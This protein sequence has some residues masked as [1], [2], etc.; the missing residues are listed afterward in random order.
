M[1][2]A[3][4]VKSDPCKTRPAKG[5]ARSTLRL[6]VVLAIAVTSCA[7]VY[8]I[9]PGLTST[10]AVVDNAG[11][12]W[13][14][15]PVGLGWD[16]DAD[17]AVFST[18]PKFVLANVASF[19]P[20]AKDHRCA[21]TT[22]SGV[23]CWGNNDFGQLGDG[24]TTSTYSPPA[25]DL[26]NGVLSVG[27]GEKHT[28]LLKSSDGVVRCWGSTANGVLGM[29]YPP[30]TLY[31][32][33]VPRQ[34]TISNVRVLAV[35]Y[36][37]NCVIAGRQREVYCWGSNSMG[38]L[39]IGFN[40]P[41]GDHAVF[42]VKIGMSGVRNIACGGA[43]TCL[44]A[45]SGALFCFGEVVVGPDAI[46]RGFFPTA[47]PDLNVIVDVPQPGTVK[48][49]LSLTLGQSHA[50]MNNADGGLSCWGSNKFGLVTGNTDYG[51]WHYDAWLR[52]FHTLAVGAGGENTCFLLN[53]GVYC[54][55]N[56]AEFQI[57]VPTFTDTSATDFEG[58]LEFP[59]PS[60]SFTVT[61]SPKPSH[62]PSPTISTTNTPIRS[63]TASRTPTHSVS[64]PSG[65]SAGGP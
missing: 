4:R 35:G 41:A 26:M 63:P 3:A 29:Q 46:G 47:L 32:S 62:S 48:F 24:T 27:V 30:N 10:C 13:G 55:G 40:A 8:Q 36:N 19:S 2:A 21:L 18:S 15:G 59:A 31:I 17:A 20:N 60:V 42:P 49:P 54:T 43:S 25:F 58:P 1:T 57:G 6:A 12:C 14:K 53:T 65:G 16:D 39:G 22:T 37:H 38:Q 64:E 7:E 9:A 51:D 61:H 45:A 5:R 11:Y 33:R 52:S 23:R 44:I 34:A 56:N 50:C 28:C